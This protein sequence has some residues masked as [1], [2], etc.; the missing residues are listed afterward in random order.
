MRLQQ[1]PGIDDSAP[2]GWWSLYQPPP[3]DAWGGTLYPIYPF[4]QYTL[5]IGGTVAVLSSARFGP[6][7]EVDR[8][9]LTFERTGDEMSLA[10]CDKDDEMM[11]KD[12]RQNLVC[13]LCIQGRV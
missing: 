11:D 4:D 6:A 2:I 10:S 12:H 1:I 9:S 3:I 7:S 5:P 8:G 13:R